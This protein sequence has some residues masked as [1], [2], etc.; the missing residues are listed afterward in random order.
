MHELREYLH[1]VG[2]NAHGHEV[3]DGI[4]AVRPDGHLVVVQLPLKP[5]WRPATHEDIATKAADNEERHAAEDELAAQEL[6]D[7]RELSEQRGREQR[8][9]D[10]LNAARMRAKAAAKKPH[11]VL[12]HGEAPPSDEQEP[13]PMPPAEDEMPPPDEETEPEPEPDEPADEEA[14][15]SADHYEG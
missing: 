9:R 1:K 5:G 2:K 8:E 14:P 6:A 13:T 3:S 4:Y 15:P 10:D 11:M 7:A 12:S